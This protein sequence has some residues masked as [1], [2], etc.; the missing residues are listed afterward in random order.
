MVETPEGSS[1]YGY[2]LK[3]AHVIVTKSQSM[4]EDRLI[5]DADK[6]K[7]EFDKKKVLD[8]ER[9]KKQM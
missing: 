9:K 6:Q 8:E 3:M 4:S 7:E 2:T 5:M 1:E